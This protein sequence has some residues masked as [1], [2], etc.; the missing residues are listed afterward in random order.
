MGLSQHA[1]YG[2]DF[3]ILNKNRANM[4]NEFIT[5]TEPVKIQDKYSRVKPVFYVG[6]AVGK[7]TFV[8]ILMPKFGV[9][10]YKD[11]GRIGYIKSGDMSKYA[12]YGAADITLFGLFQPVLTITGYVG[13][14]IGSITIDNSLAFLNV[15]PDGKWLK[16]KHQFTYNPKIGLK[17]G[18]I[19]VKVGPSFMLEPKYGLLDDWMKLGNNYY[20]FDLNFILEIND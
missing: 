15:F 12:F 13:F 10:G 8:S 20:N 2:L 4:L 6:V 18:S 16:D 7:E 3:K 9:L 14:K 5:Y 11:I 19:W 1:L 17:V